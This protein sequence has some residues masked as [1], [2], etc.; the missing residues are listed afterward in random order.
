MKKMAMVAI[1]LIASFST[2]AQNMNV[3]AYY[4]STNKIGVDF[5]HTSSQTNLILGAGVSMS[6]K[7]G[8]GS[9]YT[10]IVGPNAFGNEVYKTTSEDNV[11]IYGIV[12]YQ[13]SDGVSVMG[14]IGYGNKRKYY[15]AY[16]RSQILSPSGYYFTSIPDGG[17]IIYGINLNFKVTKNINT[18]LGMDN[19]N[20]ARVG[21]G[22]SF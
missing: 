2:F 11:G 7:T 17:N 9:D 1:A 5:T 8:V 12:G 20:T 14:N 4:G 22:F 19:F 18:S 10:G 6:L 3:T 13:L 21:V 15:N 16:D